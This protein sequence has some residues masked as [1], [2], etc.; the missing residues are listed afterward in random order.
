MTAETEAERLR[1][2]LAAKEDETI[3]AL[4]AEKEA[5]TQAEKEKALREE[6]ERQLSEERQAR[7]RFE[8]ETKAISTPSAEELTHRLHLQAEA[9][10]VSRLHRRNDELQ[11]QR[12]LI[13]EQ[14]RARAGQILIGFETC[15]RYQTGKISPA[16]F[17][18]VLA[19][20]G[21]IEAS[22]IAWEML[23]LRQ[24]GGENNIDYVEWMCEHCE[25][26]ASI[27]ST[28]A[29]IDVMASTPISP[30]LT[31]PTP[32]LRSSSPLRVSPVE[33]MSGRA[34]TRSAQISRLMASGGKLR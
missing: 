30:L 27:S 15:D 5:Q 14:V 12:Q 6:L 4:I 17:Q 19:V 10:A 7:L 34:N 25:G 23:R 9:E 16:D 22:I 18:N 33:D 32:A 24:L 28:R 1:Q 11:M 20:N 29:L 31:T 21:S 8:N 2:L 13:Q 3:A 26:E